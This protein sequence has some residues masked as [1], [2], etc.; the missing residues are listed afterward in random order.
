MLRTTRRGLLRTAVAGMGVSTLRSTENEA[1]V[2]SVKKH[3]FKYIDGH[4]HLGAF[5]WGKPTTV[6]GVLSWMAE[7]DIEKAA[8]QPLISPEAALFVQTNQAALQ[9]AK[10][11]PDRLIAY[12][13]LDPRGAQTCPTDCQPRP[14]TRGGHIAGVEGM[15]EILGRY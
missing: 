12:V 11:H 15:V 14:D 2:K 3:K 6:E 4:L 1:G 10:A 7:H 9:A 13:A 5:H 8:I